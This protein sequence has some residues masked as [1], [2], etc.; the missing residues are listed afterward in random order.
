M[1]QQ[2]FALKILRRFCMEICK[3]IST[4]IAILG[5]YMHL[6]KNLAMAKIFRKLTRTTI[7]ALWV[8]CYT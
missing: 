8:V 7:T 3:P 1:S 4:P 5:C 6:E 2:S